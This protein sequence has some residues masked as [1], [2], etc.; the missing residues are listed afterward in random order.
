MEEDYVEVE[1]ICRVVAVSEYQG[2]K[3]FPGVPFLK[4]KVGNIVDVFKV[5]KTFKK[6]ILSFPWTASTRLREDFSLEE[7]SECLSLREYLECLSLGES[8]LEAPSLAFQ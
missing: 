1:V 5:P 2:E 7:H 6:L 3:N 8:S 4:L